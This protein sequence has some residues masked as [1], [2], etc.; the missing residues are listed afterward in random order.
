MN[1]KKRFDELS[2]YKIV[3]HHVNN[4]F[5]IHVEID[6]TSAC[7]QDCLRCSYKQDI[8]GKRNYTIQKQNKSLPYKRFIELID[9]F[10]SIGVR[11]ITLSGGGEPLIYPKIESVID[12]II[13]SNIQLGVITNLSM[14]I[15]TE[16][17]SQAI[18]I[19][20]SMDAASPKVYNILHRP[21]NPDA[22]SLVCE[23]INSLAVR[24]DSLD[25][26]VNFL[27]QPENYSEI[28]SATR[29]VKELGTTYIRFAPVIAT[30]NIDYN[31]LSSEYDHLVNKSF[32]LIDDNFHVFFTKERFNS[33]EKKNKTYS[34][35]Y[36]QNIH[37]L[38]GADGNIYPCCLLK[39]Y[40]RHILGNILN[41]SFVDVWRG[42]KRKNWIDNL[43]VDLCPSCWFDETNQFI[44][45]LLT[46]NPKHVNFV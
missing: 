12:H 36:K 31:Q 4:K 8:D 3:H 10:R 39:Y 24:N 34:F 26:G 7:Q 22:F 11:A 29:L 40:D 45:Y 13:S 18:W 44:E 30:D 14:K 15:D 17:L 41:D 32:D 20:V 42:D 37:P 6:P 16:K 33:L 5:P 23:N 27:V 43:N 21:R 28:Y 38:I 19:R 2:P 25:L 46:K 35:C 9:E 1:I